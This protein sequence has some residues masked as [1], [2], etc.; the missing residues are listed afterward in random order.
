MYFHHARSLRAREQ[1]QWYACGPQRGQAQR[2]GGKESKQI[3]AESM[4]VQK[5][6]MNTQHSGQW[7]VSR[8]SGNEREFFDVNT[9]FQGKTEPKQRKLRAPQASRE[10]VVDWC[11]KHT[12]TRLFHWFRFLRAAPRRLHMEE[13]TKRSLV[14]LTTSAA[15]ISDPASQN[16]CRGHPEAPTMPR[17]PVWTR[18]HQWAYFAGGWL[19]P[20]ITM[21]LRNKP[22]EYC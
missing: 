15:Q 11:W 1:H 16:K 14:A 17:D 9:Q 12:H 22:Y 6:K 10:C 4:V 8:N 13:G 18:V 20:C 3:T 5:K 19:I 2:E 7:S 21:R